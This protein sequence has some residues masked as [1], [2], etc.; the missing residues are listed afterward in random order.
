MVQSYCAPFCLIFKNARVYFH[1]SAQINPTSQFFSV[2]LTTATV[3]KLCGTFLSTTSR[4]LRRLQQKDS[5]RIELE[6]RE[7]GFALYLNGANVARP[8]LLLQSRRMKERASR[9]AK[10]AG[11]KF[12]LP[13]H[14]PTR[15]SVCCKH[16]KAECNLKLFTSFRFKSCD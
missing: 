2:C 10:T 6:K 12:L 13:C 8:S 16:Q 4:L 7:Q 5:H 15:L 11:K 9:T 14:N 1:H 3:D